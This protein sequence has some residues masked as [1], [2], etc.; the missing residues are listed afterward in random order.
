MSIQK[1]ETKKPSLPIF[2]GIL[3]IVGSQ[4][5]LDIIAGVTLAALAIPEVMGYTT[6]A[7]MPVVTGLY[8]ILIPTALFALVRIF[9]APGGRGGFG[10]GGNHG[11]RSGRIG[12]SRLVRIRGLR[13]DPGAH[14]RRSLL[15]HRP[16]DQ[17]GVPGRF[18]V[19]DGV[20]RLPDRRRHS[21][22]DWPDLRD[23]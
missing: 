13:R 18:P 20:D 12:N 22:G 19:T 3:P 16:L 21:G 9:P 14:E 4:V 11:S 2:Q 23:A 6:I 10:H 1:S 17:A 7:G 15:I 8:T 5:P